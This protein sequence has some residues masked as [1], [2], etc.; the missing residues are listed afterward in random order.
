MGTGMAFP[1]QVIRSVN[2]ASGWIVEDL[3]LGLD[4]AAAGVPPLFCPSASVTSQFAASATGSANQR[5]R[6]EHGHIMTI[7]RL[8]PRLLFMAIAR[9]NFSLLALTLDLIVPPLSLL[10]M[11]LILMFVIAGVAALLGLGFTALIINAACLVGFATTVGLAWDRYGR[12]VL[13]ARA[14][15]SVPLY[16]LAK[17]GLYGQIL[18]GKMTAQWI[19]TDRKKP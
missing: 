4:L 19:R 15:S 18:F 1:W 10:A 16:V 11:L 6:W 2:L 8:A 3:K 9:G 5:S 12:D 7:V 14:V 17:L 13:P